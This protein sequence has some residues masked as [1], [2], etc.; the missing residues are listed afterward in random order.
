MGLIV[1]PYSQ[2]YSQPSAQLERVTMKELHLVLYAALDSL[3][4]RM[5]WPDQHVLETAMWRAQR[6]AV[7]IVRLSI[8]LGQISFWPFDSTQS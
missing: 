2:L 8:C 3:S 6:T 5:S 7:S 4:I 1:P